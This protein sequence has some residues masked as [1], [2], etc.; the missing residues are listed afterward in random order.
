MIIHGSFQGRIM[1]LSLGSKATCSKCGKDVTAL[2]HAQIA[3]N[4]CDGGASYTPP[5]MLVQGGKLPR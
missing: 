2:F 5:S 1:N 3:F 4:C